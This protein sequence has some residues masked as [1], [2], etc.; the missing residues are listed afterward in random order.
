[1]KVIAV[2]NLKIVR[3]DP[4]GSQV[5]LRRGAQM[6]LE[7][8]HHFGI[9]TCEIGVRRLASSNFVVAHLNARKARFKRLAG[10]S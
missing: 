8:P 6:L 9:G 7:P 5:L 4:C 3:P 2:A 10:E 1:M